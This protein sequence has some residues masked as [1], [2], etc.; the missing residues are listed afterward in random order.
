MPSGDSDLKL[1]SAW[2]DEPLTA[3]GD[4]I[5]V[6]DPAF[7]FRFIG[8]VDARLVADGRPRR[9]EAHWHPV[10]TRWPQLRQSPLG[11]GARCAR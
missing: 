6:Y 2:L 8:S 3:T 7:R 1:G 11:A 10:W 5:S 4:G 9:H